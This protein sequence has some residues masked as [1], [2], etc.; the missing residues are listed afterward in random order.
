MSFI[1]WN[2]VWALRSF[3]TRSFHVRKRPPVDYPPPTNSTTHR[4]LSNQVQFTN[5]PC[6]IFDLPQLSHLALR[7]TGLEGSLDQC[8]PII[9]LALKQLDLS[10]NHLEG[11]V[12]TWILSHEWKSLYDFGLHPLAFSRANLPCPLAHFPTTHLLANQQLAVALTHQFNYYP[13]FVRPQPVAA[14]TLPHPRALGQVQ[15]LAL[16]SHNLHSAAQTFALRLTVIPSTSSGLIWPGESLR[17]NLRFWKCRESSRELA[18]SKRRKPM[19]TL[20]Q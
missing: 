19:T 2:K 12:P 18:T 7:K 20:V 8:K 10:D 6:A 4:D 13:L 14:Q 15:L 16:R 9:H 5:F 1:R 3:A 17:T 11:E